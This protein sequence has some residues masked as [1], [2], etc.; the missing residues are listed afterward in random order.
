MPRV[1]L[2]FRTRRWSLAGGGSIGHLSGHSPASALFPEKITSVS[3]PSRN[4]SLKHGGAPYRCGD[5]SIRT[6]LLFCLLGRAAP[7]WPAAAGSASH[8]KGTSCGTPLVRGD[9]K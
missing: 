1:H 9:Q 3:M 2:R 7:C 5:V 8:L 6:T 4:L